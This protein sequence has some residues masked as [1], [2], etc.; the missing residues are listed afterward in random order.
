[1]LNFY[2]VLTQTKDFEAAHALE[3]RQRQDAEDALKA[4]IHE[5]D[6]KFERRLEIARELQ[7]TR[8]N[9]AV[10]SS[11]DQEAES[12]CKEA[13][14]ELVFVEASN[15]SLRE[16]KQILQRQT[17]EAD[18]WLDRWRSNRDARVTS[19]NGN[20]GFLEDVPGLVEISLLELD[21]ATCNFSNS[22]KLGEGVYGCVYKGE[23][24]DKTVAV[25]QFFV[26]SVQGPLQ[27]QKEVS[28]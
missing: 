7:K 12:W 6:R 16:E 26:H 10:L 5:R 9:V 11:R 24:L 2:S 18:C 27:F 4:T 13:A 8:T 15:A 19:R 21:S 23:L 28:I 14:A 22:F 1:M 3:A 25:K 20:S 17:M